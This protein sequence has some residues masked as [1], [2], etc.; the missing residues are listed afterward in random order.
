[1]TPREATNF[2]NHLKGT[3][4]EMNIILKSHV[5]LTDH[6]H[7][8]YDASTGRRV[9]ISYIGY[10]GNPGVDD[11]K[12]PKKSFEPANWEDATAGY[13]DIQELVACRRQ[14]GMSNRNST[15]L[16]QSL[17]LKITL[18]INPQTDNAGKD[19]NK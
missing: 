9:D 8:L 19:L 2:I 10:A 16:T 17:M 14:A 5:R 3:N 4:P 11:W 15:Y 1:M 7:L 6:G 12:R 13:P 18:S